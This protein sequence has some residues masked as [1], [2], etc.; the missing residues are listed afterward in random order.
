MLT[1]RFGGR[2][3][4][5]IANFVGIPWALALFLILGTKSLPIFWVAMAVTFFIA[6]HRRNRVR[7]GRR[8]P[9]SVVPDSLP[10]HRHRDLLQHHRGARASLVASYSGLV[11]GLFLAF[12]SL[13]GLLCT[14]A[15]RL[16]VQ[17]LVSSAD[18]GAS[19]VRSDRPAASDSRSPHARSR[20]TKR[21]R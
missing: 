3:I 5:I 11:F 4:V 20:P 10:L 2:R 9:V 6:L 14:L 19:Y 21:I 15:V 1:D 7:R 13:V 18:G 17:L 16:A 12:Y 8:V